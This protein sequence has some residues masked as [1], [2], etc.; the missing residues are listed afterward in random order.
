MIFVTYEITKLLI[1]PS[2]PNLSNT[3]MSHSFCHVSDVHRVE[4]F[5][6]WVVVGTVQLSYAALHWTDEPCQEG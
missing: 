2:P 1:A 4:I 6:F 5:I 3:L